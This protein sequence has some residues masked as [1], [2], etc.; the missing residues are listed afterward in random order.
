MK[1]DA[2]LKKLFQRPP[3]RLLSHVLGQE[4]V[5]KQI[6][7]TDL[8]TV[9]NLHPDLLF[10]TEDGSLI[11][12]EL[13]GYA[14]DEF[15]CRNLIYFGLV[16]RDYK[17]PPTQ[18]V[19]WI[20][21]KS[22]GVAAGLHYEPS[23]HYQYRVIDVREMDGEFLLQSPDVNES[24]FAILCKL[25]DAPGVVLR[26][27]RRISQLP[28]SE[29]R[30]AAAQL[31]V[32]SGSRG[33]TRLVEAEVAQMP[34]TIDIHENEFLEGI[35]QEGRGEGHQ[36]GHQEGRGE[37]ARGILLGL[38]DQKFGPVSSDVKQRIEAADVAATERWIRRVVP[39]ATLTEVFD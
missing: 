36:E 27:L 18:I 28:V 19:F 14:M 3:N 26:I 2:T 1:Y 33:L 17:R 6:L 15:A 5:V 12:A 7:P 4:I 16:L 35:Y 11:H 32:L 22:V 13:H 21:E 8:I 25:E 30:E 24:I 20:G 37:T 29:Q 23:L 38:L 31:L 39:S 34:V 10:E 9:Q